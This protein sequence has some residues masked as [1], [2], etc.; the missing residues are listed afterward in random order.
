[1]IDLLLLNGAEINRRDALGRTPLVIAVKAVCI[2]MKCVYMCVRRM[3]EC[4]CLCVY[5]RVY[6]CVCCV[7]VRCLF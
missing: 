4:V 6:A 1:V 7:C 5:V 2:C 3:C